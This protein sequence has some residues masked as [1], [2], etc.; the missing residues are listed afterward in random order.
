MARVCSR[1]GGSFVLFH[2][3]GRHFARLLTWSVSP[4]RH[5][6]H[7]RIDTS[8]FGSR[9][10]F[11]LLRVTLLVSQVWLSTDGSRGWPARHLAG[12]ARGARHSRSNR[13]MRLPRPAHLAHVAICNRCNR[14]VRLP[15]LAHLAHVAICNRRNRLVRFSRLAHLAH[16]AM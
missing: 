15:R 14:H 3:S 2:V 8:S 4:F 6:S 5:V 13:H 10:R 12:G 7:A 11:L 1:G 16:V 9:G